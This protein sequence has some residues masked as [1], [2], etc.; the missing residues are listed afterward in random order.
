[1]PVSVAFLNGW[2]VLPLQLA[3]AFAA[4]G[5]SVVAQVASNTVPTV[6]RV[7]GRGVFCGRLVGL[8]QLGSCSPHAFSMVR[9]KWAKL[10][11][12]AALL[13]IRLRVAQSWHTLYCGVHA[14]RPDL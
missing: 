13:F 6:E 7:S 5:S 10:A 8:L 11:V 12:G 9:F 3:S 14:H 4:G 1:M 2:G